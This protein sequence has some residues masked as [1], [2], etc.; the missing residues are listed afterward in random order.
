MT[1]Q[2]K[3][4]RSKTQLLAEIERLQF[5]LEEAEET[6]EAIRHA[7]VDALVVAGPQGEQ[8][9][10]ITGAEHIYRVIVETMNEAALTV[11]PDGTILFCNQRFCDLMKTPV[12]GAMGRK[13]TAFAAQPQQ[14]AL[15]KILAEAQAAPVQRH[16]L[17]RATDGTSVPVQLAAST[18][19]TGDHVSICLVAS[20]LTELEESAHSIRVLREHQQALEESEARFR[21]MFEASHDA[22]IITDD[23][24]VCVQ[25]NPAVAAI[26][27]L[28]PERLL[29]HKVSHFL[30]DALDFPAFWRDFLADGSIR[31]ELGLIAADGQRRE[32]DFYGV[33]NILPGRHMSV[34]RDIT[35][36]KRTQRALEQMNE[37]LQMQAEE[38]EEQSEEL[39]IQTE[40]LRVQTEELFAANMSLAES[41]RRYRELVQNANS[42]IVRWRR[43]GTVTF[44]NDYAQAFFG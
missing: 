39:R 44:F 8:V 7:E 9:F 23:E 34:L 38:M 19:Q 17:L 12:Q 15:R 41:E 32:V 40:E 2:G 3:D 36:R 33:T 22:I 30:D 42:A 27:G 6:L 25:A 26:F 10:S 31:N 20:D 24:G 1:D 21:T 13:V 28:P 43:D 37:R 11:D 5:R 14:A 35:E 16:L 4:P 29:G 18:L